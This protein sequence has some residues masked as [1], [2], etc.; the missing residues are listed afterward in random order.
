[1]ST[2]ALRRA[3]L[4]GMLFDLLAS[5][6]TSERV[7]LL[8]TAYDTSHI[9]TLRQI[10]DELSDRDHQYNIKV[11]QEISIRD[12]PIVITVAHSPFVFC[13]AIAR[14]VAHSKCS[15]VKGQGLKRRV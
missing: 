12:R 9:F 10:N 15:Y 5:N 13:K 14:V 4:L 2:S 11:K 3:L 1:M 6:A 7:L 8:P